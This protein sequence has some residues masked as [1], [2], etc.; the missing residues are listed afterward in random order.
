M[1]N[2]IVGNVVISKPDPK[3]PLLFK[4]LEKIIDNSK[5][6]KGVWQIVFAD[7][8]MSSFLA[9]QDTTGNTGPN[10]SSF[11]TFISL[12]ILVKIVGLKKFPFSPNFSPPHMIQ[13]P[14]RRQVNICIV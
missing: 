6:P 10:T 5:L 12:F 11:Q 1:Q 14:L 3:L 13:A 4:S 8:E 2:L 9:D 7:R